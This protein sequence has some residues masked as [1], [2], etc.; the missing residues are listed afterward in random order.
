[1][2]ENEVKEELHLN[3]E[4]D[5]IHDVININMNEIKDA[6]DVKEIVKE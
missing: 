3:V 6:I 4:E 1:V 2:D 5:D